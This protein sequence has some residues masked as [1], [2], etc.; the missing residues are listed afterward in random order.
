VRRI[1]LFLLIAFLTISVVGVAKASSHWAG[2]A[3]ESLFHELIP[4]T[5]RFTHPVR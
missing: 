4:N 2:E 1:S 5:G 3:P